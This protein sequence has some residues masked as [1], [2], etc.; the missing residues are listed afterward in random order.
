MRFGSGD[1]THT[2]DQKGSQL[3]CSPSAIL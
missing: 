2:E 1:V 3:L